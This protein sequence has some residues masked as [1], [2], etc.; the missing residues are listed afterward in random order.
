LRP[1]KTLNRFAASN[2]CFDGLDAN[3][4]CVIGQAATKVL[5]RAAV[6]ARVVEADVAHE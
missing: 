3:V 6:G 2:R 5:S 1:K 4:E